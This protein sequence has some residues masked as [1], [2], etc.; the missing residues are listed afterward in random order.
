[1]HNVPNGAQFYYKVSIDVFFSLHDD[2]AVCDA[3]AVDADDSVTQR[4]LM[5][6]VH[7]F[8]LL[9]PLVKHIVFDIR[10]DTSVLL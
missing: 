2:C 4:N 7:S 10:I 5:H 8:K 6:C 9:S 3:T 1:M